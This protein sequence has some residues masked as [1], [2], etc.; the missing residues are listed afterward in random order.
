MR[1]LDHR[2]AMVAGLGS[3]VGASPFVGST[4]AAAQT[5]LVAP[6]TGRT[7]LEQALAAFRARGYGLLLAEQGVASARADL[8]AGGA[9]INP[10]LTGGVG[11]SLLYNSNTCPGCAELAWSAGLTDNGALVNLLA[12]LRALRVDVGRAALNV[13]EMDSLDTRR[14]LETVVK[15]A[16]SQAALADY[17]VRVASEAVAMS[18]ETLLLVEARYRAGSVSEADVARAD[19]AKLEVEQS[20]DSAIAMARTTKIALSFLMGNRGTAR[21]LAVD[22]RSLDRPLDRWPSEPDPT[23]L[24]RLALA[25]RADLKAAAYDEQ[26]ASAQV[27]LSRRQRFPALAWSIGYAQQGSGA[28]AQQPP[29]V[30][31]GLSTPLPIFYQNQG[32]IARAEANLHA[33]TIQ[34]AKT[35]AQVMADVETALSAYQAARLRLVRMEEHILPRSREARD[36][37]RVQYQKGAASLL[38]LIDAQRTNIAAHAEHVQDLVDFW[39]AVFALEQAVGGPWSSPS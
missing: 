30:T 31:V 34:H 13:A 28:S 33:R 15:Q 21:D 27:A 23:T 2:V 39:N 12:G 10:G 38:E 4:T 6:E 32:E 8:R 20:L 7:T 5:I 22:P 19:T 37:T 11:K 25:R 35:Q 36:L 14:Q 29:T 1:R 24:L 26:R 18:N 9:V 16:F 17:N 3:I